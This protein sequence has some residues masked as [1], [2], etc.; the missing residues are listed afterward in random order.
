Q[1]GHVD[2]SELPLVPKRAS[3]LY[4]G[5][6]SMQIPAVGGSGFSANQHMLIAQRDQRHAE[7]SPKRLL[8]IAQR[9]MLRL[10]LRTLLGRR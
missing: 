6:H 4:V 3:V 5:Q 7:S 2:H 8:R 1:Y 9:A 10:S